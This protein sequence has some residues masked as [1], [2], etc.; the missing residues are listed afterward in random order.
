MRTID[1]TESKLY[2]AKTLASLTVKEGEA[3]IAEMTRNFQNFR[4][5]RATREKDWEELNRIFGM[6]TKLGKS[7]AGIVSDE[8][9]RGDIIPR[10]VNPH[11]TTS[12]DAIS[13]NDTV[14]K[15]VEEINNMQATLARSSLDTY[16]TNLMVTTFPT[17]QESLFVQRFDKTEPQQ[18]LAL[19]TLMRSHYEVIDQ[20][21]MVKLVF[22]EVAKYG[23]CIVGYEWLSETELHWVKDEAN[24]AA[25]VKKFE[26]TYYAG[27]ITPVPIQQIYF[28]TTCQDKNKALVI[29]KKQLSPTE[30]L[31]CKNYSQRRTYEELACQIIDT[32]PMLASRTY[33]AEGISLTTLFSASPEPYTKLDVYE[34]WGDFK[35]GKKVYKNYVLEYTNVNTKKSIDNRQSH[36]QV[37]RFEPNPYGSKKPYIIV[38]P[39]CDS[40][41]HYPKSPYEH[42]LPHFKAIA[43]LQTAAKDIISASAMRPM[44]ANINFLTAESKRF[45]E[46]EAITNKT[47]LYYTGEIPVS[48]IFSRMDDNQN[49]NATV[50]MQLVD[51]LKREVR[52]L[53]GETEAMAGGAAPQYMKTGVAMAFQQGSQNRLGETA[54]TIEEQLLIPMGRRTLDYFSKYL[55]GGQAIITG[56]GA[57]PLGEPFSFDTL[58]NQIILRG[59]SYSPNNQLNTQNLMQ[60]LQM[61]ITSPFSAIIGDGGML[62]MLKEAL[63]MMGMQNVD[64]IIPQQVIQD[65]ATKRLSLVE[66]LGGMFAQVKTPPQGQG[67]PQQGQGQSPQEQAPPQEGGQGL[68]A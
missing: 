34:C 23:T 32:D 40:A 54:K 31:D 1:E 14:V 25:Y 3:L 59:S 29:R 50:V 12:R 11:A 44:I 51:S 42:A 46:E 28:D 18:A 65:T 48:S 22:Y 37:L 24:P 36:P 64:D 7:T 63:T 55:S 30:I 21:Q 57:L 67:Q 10:D 13:G 16:V 15:K 5:S 39:F 20:K 56:R 2:L 60:T 43:Q 6:S 61:L 9:L 52:D 38:Q 4:T 47:V 62:R 17:G 45:L 49:S 8:L 66:K 68:T 58:S 19:Q 35:I 41:S 33:S 27:K 26:N 53:I